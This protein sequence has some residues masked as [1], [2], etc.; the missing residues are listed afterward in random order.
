MRGNLKI[1]RT[2]SFNPFDFYRFIEAYSD[3]S[4]SVHFLVSDGIIIDFAHLFPRDILEKVRIQRIL[5]SY[6]LQRIL[7]DSNTDPHFIAVRSEIMSSWGASIIEGIY[8]VLKIKSYYHGCRVYLNVVGEK[9]VYENYFGKT[10]TV[11]VRN[12]RVNGGL[13]EWDEQYQQ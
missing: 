6:Q 9:G 11:P 4:D 5:T 7:M 2:K 13:Y 3:N 1:F 12:K 8:D 10:L